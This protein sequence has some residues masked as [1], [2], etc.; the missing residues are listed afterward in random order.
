MTE[1]AIMIEGQMGLTWPRWQAIAEAVDGGGFAGLFRS[2]HF[3][4]PR[5][6]LEDA[7]EMT[8]SLA[9]L[10]TNTHHIHFGPLVAP[11]SSRHA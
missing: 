11:V 3:T 2:D 7:L 10:A 8:I 9:Y 6:P 4:N 1:L 5:G